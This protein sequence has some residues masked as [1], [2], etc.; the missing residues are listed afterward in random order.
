MRIELME[1]C[2]YEMYGVYGYHLLMYTLQNVYLYFVFCMK[3]IIQKYVGMTY[4]R[5]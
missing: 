2:Y 1:Q 5:R 3:K 4:L